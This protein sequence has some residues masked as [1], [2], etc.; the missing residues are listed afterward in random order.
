MLQSA[1]I[2]RMYN[3]RESCSKKM[4]FHFWC[5]SYTV[6]ERGR[7]GQSRGPLWFLKKVSFSDTVHSPSP[8]GELAMLIA[9]VWAWGLH[10]ASKSGVKP[11]LSRLSRELP[12]T[13]LLY[14]IPETFTWRFH[15]AFSPQNF[16][17]LLQ[18]LLSFL[19]FLCRRRMV[20]A[21]W[22]QETKSVQ[23]DDG[24][25]SLEEKKKFCSLPSLL[26]KPGFRDLL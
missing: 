15:V 7:L 22:G 5:G 10:M 17:C 23:S 9:G 16:L 4:W 25:E 20:R 6:W 18:F 14:L 12:N 8:V 11:C 21:E 24:T 19:D 1:C 26:S 3:T 13:T 2:P